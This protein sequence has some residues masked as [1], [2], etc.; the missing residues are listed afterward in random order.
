MR[1]ERSAHLI[2][3][4]TEVTFIKESQTLIAEKNYELPYYS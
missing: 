4:Q 3:T 1:E 2:T